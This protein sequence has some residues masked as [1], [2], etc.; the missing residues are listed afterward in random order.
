VQI[1]VD[2]SSFVKGFLQSV[3]SISENARVEVEVGEM[4]SLVH[5]ADNTAILLARCK[6]ACNGSLH[7]N[8]PNL[9]KF[10]RLLGNIDGDVSF[11]VDGNKIRYSEGKLSFEYF[12]L[13]DSYIG[14]TPLNKSKI[15]SLET[16]A[17]FI[18]DGNKLSELLKLSSVTSD[19]EKVYFYTQDGEV[20]AEL[21]DREKHNVT[22]VSISVADECEG[23]ISSPIPFLL[24]NFRNISYT[25]ETQLIFKINTS[26]KLA[27][28][29]FKPS[30]SVSL[31]YVFSGLVR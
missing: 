26:L 20:I 21:N 10:A 19:T 3:S 13:D 5:S 23:D 1:A 24:N 11:T 14:K 22:N 7:F 12:L 28:V 9:K 16:G 27:V 2:Q 4:E 30:S 6:C 8:I 15:Q 18:L 31:K 29:Q 25:R 17:Q